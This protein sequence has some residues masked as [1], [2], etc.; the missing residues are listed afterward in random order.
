MNSTMTPNGQINLA[1]FT[2]TIINANS[3]FSFFSRI[4]ILNFTS[5][6]FD[7]HYFTFHISPLF[8]VSIKQRNRRA[9]INN[10]QQT[11]THIITTKRKNKCCMSKKIKRKKNK[12]RTVRA[13]IWH[14]NAQIYWN[15]D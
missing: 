4:C 8:R 10:T 6:M 7:I 14:Q 11:H 12:I 9:N 5:S 1:F 13:T 2:D 3:D 15:F